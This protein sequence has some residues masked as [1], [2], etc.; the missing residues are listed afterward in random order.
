[1]SEPTLTKSTGLQI[2]IGT[3]VWGALL[4]VSALAGPT[5]LALTLG[6]GVLVMAWGGLG[7][8]RC[9]PLAAPAVSSSWVGQC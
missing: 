3:A 5:F 9:Q 8:H 4:A 6:L 7:H 1:M 2:A